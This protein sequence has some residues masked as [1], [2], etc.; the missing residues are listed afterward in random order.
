MKEHMCK[1]HRS[2]RWCNPFA[3]VFDTA[4]VATCDHGKQGCASVV[5]N[6]AFWRASHSCNVKFNLVAMTL[7][8]WYTIQL[9]GII[10][11]GSKAELTRRNLGLCP[12]N[13]CVIPIGFMV[14]SV[15]G[16][17]VIAMFLQRLTTCPL[18]QHDRLGDR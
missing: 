6:A 16:A 7:H 12:G 14:A 11:G 10:H 5:A 9:L 2:V 17:V 13:M 18:L 8:E 15:F 3:Q 1:G 4:G